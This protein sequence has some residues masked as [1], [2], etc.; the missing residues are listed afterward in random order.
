[1]TTEKPIWFIVDYLFEIPHYKILRPGM[2]QRLHRVDDR[3]FLAE[4]LGKAEKAR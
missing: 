3:L 2:A 4:T 1:M